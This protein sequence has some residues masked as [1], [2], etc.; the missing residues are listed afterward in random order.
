MKIAERLPKSNNTP[1]QAKVCWTHAGVP[2]AEPRLCSLSFL[3]GGAMLGGQELNGR[4]RIDPGSE[5]RQPADVEV[6]R[7]LCAPP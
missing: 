3:A 1:P 7:Q 2:A 5:P 6:N 4:R